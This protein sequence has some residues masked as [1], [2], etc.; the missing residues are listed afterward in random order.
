M[1]TTLPNTCY[2]YNS[3][4]HITNYYLIRSSEPHLLIA[5]SYYEMKQSVE[6]LQYYGSALELEPRNAAALVNT[7]VILNGLGRHEEAVSHAER[8]LKIDPSMVE[9][10]SS[11]I[12]PLYVF[13]KMR[14]NHAQHS[15]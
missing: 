2:K 4:T 6:E 15:Q 13:L 7:A 8:A 12:L 9:V 5:S 10:R 1:I 3:I 11:I 14:A